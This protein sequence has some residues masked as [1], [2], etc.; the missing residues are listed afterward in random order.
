VSQ[1]IPVSG[2]VSHLW[3]FASGYLIRTSVG[4]EG[5]EALGCCPT[6]SKTEF[7]ASYFCGTE[8]C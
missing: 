2:N 3:N 7:G 5:G 4:G 1:G 6:P 8:A